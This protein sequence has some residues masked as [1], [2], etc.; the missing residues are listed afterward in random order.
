MALLRQLDPALKQERADVTRRDR[1][2][3]T[4]VY[5]LYT[6][7]DLRHTGKGLVVP[8]IREA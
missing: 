3:A 7:A 8:V 6:S 1:R 2:P 5:N 4:I